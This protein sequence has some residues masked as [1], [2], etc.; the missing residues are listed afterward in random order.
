MCRVGTGEPDDP[1][2]GLEGDIENEQADEH[3]AEQAHGF[4]TLVDAVL[5]DGGEEQQRRRSA[6]EARDDEQQRCEPAV[7]GGASADDTEEGADAA[8][9]D[10][11]DG[12]GDNRKSSKE[13]SVASVRVVRD[14]AETQCEQ[15][16]IRARVSVESA[17]SAKSWRTDNHKIATS[18]SM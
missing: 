2:A 4:A 14:V 6:G 9:E 7:P 18:S 16:E 17:R 3:L 8:G 13:P 5:E 12:E 1:L 15:L 10:S 11:S